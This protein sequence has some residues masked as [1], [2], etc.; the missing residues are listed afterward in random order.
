MNNFTKCNGTAKRSSILNLLCC[1]MGLNKLQVLKPLLV[2]VLFVF[3]SVSVFSQQRSTFYEV[4][5][6]ERPLGLTAEQAM[7]LFPDV[8]LYQSF[9]IEILY[10]PQAITFLTSTIGIIE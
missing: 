6:S 7:A 4:C 2:L 8:I 1:S 9:F 3:S 10:D 5:F